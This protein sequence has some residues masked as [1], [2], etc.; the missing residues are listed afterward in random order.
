MAT[1]PGPGLLFGL[2]LL[3][4]IIGGTL[5]KL[6][7]IPRVVGYLFSG[8]ALH[9][10]LV[11]LLG[12]EEGSDVEKSLEQNAGTLRAVKNLALGLILFSIG[13]VFERKHIDRVGARIL[14]ISVAETGLV[15]VLVAAATAVVTRIE[16]GS[17]TPAIALALLLA[18]AALETAPAATLFVLRE[19]DA[20]GPATDTILS[21]I[22]ANNIL[23]II[24][25]YIAFYS[26]AAA[27]WIELS[28]EGG[29]G[30]IVRL[31]FIIFGSLLLG[32]ILGLALSVIH[33]K[34]PAPDA[35][36]IF[37]AAF[38]VVGA[39]EEWLNN[40]PHIGVSYSFLLT[41]L[42]IGAV[43][44]NV[45]IDP[46]RLNTTLKT[47]GG[48]IFVGFFVLAGYQMHIEELVSIGLVGGAYVVARTLGKVL[49]CAYGIRW[50]G[51]GEEVKP[52]VGSAML[53]QAAVAIG[54]ADFVAVAWNNELGP[55]FSSIV[56]G[57]V[58]IFELAGPLLTKWTAVRAGE[59]K[60]ITLL[61][62]SNTGAGQSVMVRTLQALGNTIGLR[63][64]SSG[65]QSAALQVRH[66]MRRNVKFIR[67]SDTLEEVLYFVE[68]SQFDSFPVVDDEGLVGMIP[69]AD[70]RDIIYES[71]L[72]ELVTAIDLIDPAIPPVAADESLSHALE[73]FATH[74]EVG[75][76]AVVDAD[77]SRNVIGVIE[78]RDVLRA[79][80]REQ[81]KTA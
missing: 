39:G 29:A 57:S 35:I 53:C 16:L 44:A 5:A 54:L 24:G 12:A 79:M 46:E 48:P 66:V 31:T 62:R 11:N 4:G 6:I 72:A 13:S 21:L 55:R 9:M 7:R 64:Q 67:A 69:F 25:F 61:R 33:S 10:V 63:R 32:L 76:L 43:F 15:F 23:C 50:S 2:M 58:V 80:H 71:S 70:L 26:L 47:L 30:V 52:Y 19:Y 40:H 17:W 14:R 18:A 28:H 45:A 74:K 59:V 38:L 77:G 60:A 1:A 3:A 73:L 8:I 78:Q 49:G 27:G 56:L 51:E 65:E 75:S 22:G 42:V 41:S 37:F 20:K 36:L 81:S 68:R 34:L